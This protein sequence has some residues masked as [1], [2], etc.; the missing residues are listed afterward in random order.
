MVRSEACA[1]QSHTVM[2]APGRFGYATGDRESIA[3]PEMRVG[4]GHLHPVE[5]YLSV[6][7]VVPVVIL[8]DT[9]SG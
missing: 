1:E 6:P 3:L 4:H 2:D 5:E 9:V 7:A 8:A